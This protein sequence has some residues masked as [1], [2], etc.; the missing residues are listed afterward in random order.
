[1]ATKKNP[2]QKPEEEVTEATEEVVKTAEEPNEDAAKALAEAKAE[3]EKARKEAEALKK[4]LDA[5]KKPAVRGR[6]DDAQT[7]R[8][9]AN[10]AAEKGQNPWDIKVSVRAP[11]RPGKEDPWYWLSVNGQTVQV[12]A[13][14]KYH[15]LKLPW[16]EALINALEAERYAGDYQDTLE[17]FDPVTN[18]HPD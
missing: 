4:Q 17:V 16:A 12:P 14:D 15:E 10:E 9:A 6:G 5:A 8:E 3:L 11:R 13:D 2:V 7:V 1:M 18:P